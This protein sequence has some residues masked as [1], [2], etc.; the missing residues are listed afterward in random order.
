VASFS[1]LQVVPG[2]RLRAQS[3][4]GPRA[5]ASPGPRAFLLSECSASRAPASRP[6]LHNRLSSELTQAF[7]AQPL[8]PGSG[9][10]R[11]QA[12][13]PGQAQGKCPAQSPGLPG[14]HQAPG[15]APSFLLLPQAPG[16]PG[17]SPPSSSRP[18]GPSFSSPGPQGLISPGSG[19]SLR[20]Q[21]QA[22]AQSRLRS[23]SSGSGVH[24]R[25]AAGGRYRQPC[26]IRLPAG[27]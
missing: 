4:S 16:F 7:P 17:L 6:R 13:A 8:S 22:Q 20:A 14:A 24:N 18:P 19:P 23:R 10:L 25:G 2:P 9:R 3:S 5:Q 12:A 26:K 21:A 15:P 1:R 27:R 11:R